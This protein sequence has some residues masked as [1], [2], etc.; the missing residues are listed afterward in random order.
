VT[1]TIDAAREFILFLGSTDEDSAIT[2]FG[3]LP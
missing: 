2:S 3:R 1:E